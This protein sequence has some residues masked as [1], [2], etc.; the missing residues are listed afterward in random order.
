MAAALSVHIQEIERCWL[1]LMLAGRWTQD[2]QGSRPG[3]VKVHIV[4]NLLPFP[5]LVLEAVLRLPLR[6]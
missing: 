3:K 6:V 2:A 5:P 1:L 4:H